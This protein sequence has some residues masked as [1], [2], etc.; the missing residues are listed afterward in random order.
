M[1]MLGN[2]AQRKNKFERQN[3]RNL[4]GHDSQ[5]TLR[6]ETEG[7]LHKAR[8]ESL[9]VPSSSA[10]LLL[11]DTSFRP[12]YANQEALA[13]LTYPV[14]LTK[15]GN[16]DSF[17]EGRVQTLFTGLHGSRLL[18]CPGPLA[19]GR[20]CY[21][22]QIFSVR[23]PLA[24]GAKP[25]V[26]VLL[27]RGQ[28]SPLDLSYLSGRYRLTQREVETVGHLVQGC[29]TAKIA[30]RMQIS[31]NTVKAFLR[32]IMMKMSAGSRAGIIARI[33]QVSGSIT[34]ETSS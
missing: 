14:N 4:S 29:S 1:Q 17:L 26:A 7:A 23:S 19:S 13:A 8:S 28:K 31:P 3:L 18:K 30:E 22:V 12:L 6:K 11:L 15:D 5:T 25:A 33:L 2:I 34:R 9:G 32:S 21:N 16:F 27:D 20:R 24:N 10:G